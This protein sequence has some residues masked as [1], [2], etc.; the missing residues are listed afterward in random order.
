MNKFK[1]RIMIM[2]IMGTNILLFAHPHLFAGVDIDF[3]VTQSNLLVITQRWM[4][5][6]LT[7]M[8][9]LED[10]DSNYDEEICSS[11][12][13]ELKKTVIPGLKEEHFYT[14]LVIDDENIVLQEITDFSVGTYDIYVYY[15]FSMTVPF[16]IN[17]KGNEIKINV[18]DRDFY[19]KFYVNSS[20][21]LK[22]LKPEDVS[23]QIDVY[24]NK[25]KSYYFG[26]LNPVEVKLTLS[27]E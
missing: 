26:Q 3:D 20:S 2:L 22:V 18:F 24:E 4:F 11:E 13:I 21:G 27:K 17:D 10:F 12:L 9:I 25:S 1:I 7:S 14:D 19:T 15:Q 5:D 16:V 23:H 8:I 6:D